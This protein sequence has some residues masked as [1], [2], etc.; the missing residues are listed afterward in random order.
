MDEADISQMLDEYDE[1]PGLNLDSILSGI[2]IANVP[3]N[4]T[5]WWCGPG[6][7]PAFLVLKPCGTHRVFVSKKIK[8]WQSLFVISTRLWTN[9]SYAIHSVFHYLFFFSPLPFWNFNTSLRASHPLYP[10]FLSRH[11]R[12]LSSKAVCRS[13]IRGVFFF[14]RDAG[15][16]RRKRRHLIRCGSLC[17]FFLLRQATPRLLR[18]EDRLICTLYKFPFIF[19]T[20]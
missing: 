19:L 7:F 13:D 2:P 6:P 1:G 14:V 12:S 8:L 5:W 17:S 4:S 11:L 18:I 9:S 10:L 20:K 16:S 3:S 15:R